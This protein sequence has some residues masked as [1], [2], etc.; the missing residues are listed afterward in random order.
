MLSS[1]V[2]PWSG[3]SRD[4]RLF[5]TEEKLE[6]GVFDKPVGQVMPTPGLINVIVTLPE[7]STLLASHVANRLAH[8]VDEDD[9]SEWRALK[10]VILDALDTLAKGHGLGAKEHHH[11]A[12][13]HSSRSYA[14]PSHVPVDLFAEYLLT[15]K[16]SLHDSGGAVQVDDGRRKYTAYAQP[17]HAEESKKTLSHFFGHFAV[18]AKPL[19]DSLEGKILVA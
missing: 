5:R 16:V 12:Q 18:A 6:H 7:D 14:H 19:L 4:F 11:V 3:V 15:G 2:K 10:K 9:G 13:A 1:V 8:I 17:G